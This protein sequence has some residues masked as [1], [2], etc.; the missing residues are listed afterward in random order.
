MQP[1]MT[2]L[3]FSHFWS[4]LI[5]TLTPITSPHQPP[6]TLS[7][8]IVFSTPYHV[9]LKLISSYQLISSVSSI[10]VP[11]Y[12]SFSFLSTFFSPTPHSTHANILDF[13]DVGL[14]RTCH[15]LCDM[16]SMPLENSTSSPS[17]TSNLSSLF[18]NS[19]PSTP[20]NTH[21]MQT[22]A[23]N[24]INKPINKLNLIIVHSPSH[25]EPI[26]VSH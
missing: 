9:P 16:P 18:P 4:T 2:I 11:T 14:T 24:H 10:L 15:P 7:L 1:N 5:T 13:G 17:Y 22:R 3:S 19:K 21:L 12:S 8:P 23:K 20:H 25:L 6:E 26:I